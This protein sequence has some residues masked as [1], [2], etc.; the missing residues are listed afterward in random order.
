MKKLKIEAA[1]V[2][3]RGIGHVPKIIQL[4][5]IARASSA[6]N[7]GL[8]Q[9]NRSIARVPPRAVASAFPP[10][11]ALH[12]AAAKKITAGSIRARTAAGS[13][14]VGHSSIS[15]NKVSSIKIRVNWKKW[16]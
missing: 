16:G 11:G 13:M 9:H 5:N 15:K 7:N 4:T 3:F 2:Q 14:W 12:E 10:F 8:C 1:A 6:K